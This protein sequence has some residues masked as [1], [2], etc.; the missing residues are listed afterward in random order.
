MT[1]WFFVFDL[2]GNA[3]A[4]IKNNEMFH[5]VDPDHLSGLGEGFVCDTNGQKLTG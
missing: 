3:V 5:I 2:S 4:M 1:I